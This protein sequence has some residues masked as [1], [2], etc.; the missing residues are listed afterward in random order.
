MF[1]KVSFWR[2]GIYISTTVMSVEVGDYRFPLPLRLPEAFRFSV[3]R[4]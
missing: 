3:Q 2:A 4:K 1:D